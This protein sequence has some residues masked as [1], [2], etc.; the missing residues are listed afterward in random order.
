MP[1]CAEGG[2]LGIL[3]GLIGVIQAT[4]PVKLILGEGKPLV[5]RLLLYDA[6]EMTFRE[7]KVRK[8]PRCPICGP[9]PTI[10]GLYRLPGV[11]RRPRRGNRVQPRRSRR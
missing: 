7:M 11:L 1:N 3:P 6:L 8:N 5:G 2:V 9:N 10:R 4:K